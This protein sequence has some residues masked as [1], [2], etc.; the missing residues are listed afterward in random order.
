[1]TSRKAP[2]LS[3]QTNPCDVTEES[4]RAVRRN[5]TN[6]TTKSARHAARE[7][8]VTLKPEILD[9]VNKGAQS[10]HFDLVL[11]LKVVLMML[12]GMLFPALVGKCLSLDSLHSQFFLTESI[13]FSP[14]LMDYTPTGGHL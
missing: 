7:V 13:P 10:P 14:S 6:P 12:P 11:L 1:M 2:A 4:I 5:T 9:L 8:I 3:A